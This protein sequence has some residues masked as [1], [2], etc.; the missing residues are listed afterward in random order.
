MSAPRVELGTD[1]LKGRHSTIELCA[2]NVFVLSEGI[3]P[4]LL[5]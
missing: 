2:L 3:E 4:S 5:P 1:G